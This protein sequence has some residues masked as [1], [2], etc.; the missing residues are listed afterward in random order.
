[1]KILFVLKQKKNVETFA[2]T[3]RALTDRGHVVTLA[4]QEHSDARADQYRDAINSP[5]FSMV[6]G[7]PNPGVLV[8]PGGITLC[9]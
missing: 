5:R 6:R 9:G 1:M 8:G 4:V 2:A 7:L 3:I